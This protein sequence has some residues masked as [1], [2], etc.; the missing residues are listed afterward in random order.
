[1]DGEGLPDDNKPSIYQLF[2][3]LFLDKKTKKINIHLRVLVYTQ[4]GINPEALSVCKRRENRIETPE[5]C[6][7][8]QEP[9][10]QEHE[11]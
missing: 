3:V 1:M 7:L 6:Q 11:S 8:S 2:L 5:D 10:D 9:R 4:K